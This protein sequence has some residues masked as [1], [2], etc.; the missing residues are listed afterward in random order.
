M[1]I[2]S[3]RFD[4]TKSTVVP[5]LPAVAVSVTVSPWTSCGSWPAVFES[6]AAAASRIERAAVSVTFEVRE[7]TRPSRMSPEISV[8]VTL[9]STITSSQPVPASAR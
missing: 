9:P 3:S 5:M 8:S 1:L 4:S 6:L 7:R 2:A